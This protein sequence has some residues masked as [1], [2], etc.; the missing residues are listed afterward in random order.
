MKIILSALLVL[1][2]FKSFCFA[3]TKDE[4]K[5]DFEKSIATLRSVCEKI[6][7]KTSDE[8]ECKAY[9]G[10]KLPRD[11]RFSKIFTLLCSCEQTQNN[12]L[13]SLTIEDGIPLEDI[14]FTFYCS[15]IPFLKNLYD[16]K[17][18]APDSLYAADLEECIC[19]LNIYRKYFTF[20]Q[21]ILSE[22]LKIENTRKVGP[23][24]MYAV[25][26][27]ERVNLFHM[28]RIY[29]SV[30]DRV[31]ALESVLDLLDLPLDYKEMLK[32]HIESVIKSANFILTLNP[33][34]HR[35]LTN[36]DRMDL[37]TLDGIYKSAFLSTENAIGL[38]IAK[39]VAY[40]PLNLKVGE[41][42][43]TKEQQ[44]LYRPLL[45]KILTSAHLSPHFTSESQ[46]RHGTLRTRKSKKPKSKASLASSSS[47]LSSPASFLSSSP[48]SFS[49]DLSSPA[50]FPS[51]SPESFSS[52]L[53][54]PTTSSSS[55]P[56]SSPSAL[57]SCDLIEAHD[58][59]DNT[60]F[61]NQWLTNIIKASQT[62]GDT[63]GIFLKAKELQSMLAKNSSL[64]EQV[65]GA[66]AALAV[67][68]QNLE[69]GATKS[70]LSYKVPPEVEPGFLYFMDTPLCHMNGLRFRFI[71]ALFQKLGVKVD[72]MREGSRIHFSY[73]GQH[74]AIHLHDKHNG[75][76]DG[77]RISSLR[78][79]LINCG[80][81]YSETQSSTASSKKRK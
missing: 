79:F 54:S 69:Q 14:S 27:D 58:E 57:S 8:N 33:R 16:E 65:Q 17:N 70:S 18:I 48:E 35:A 51:S 55:S 9:F 29:R 47:A 62:K 43:L 15:V 40:Q 12:Q 11:N 44:S 67:K 61:I 68:L 74:T 24:N 31:K 42:F 20:V 76:L 50:S 4:F 1:C 23:L 81:I 64:L 46:P 75:E 63:F 59:M 45:D 49:G 5:H 6:Q 36:R 39:A 2:F 19:S 60:S 37:V 34:S 78:Q 52:D 3:G 32:K 10:N 30:L 66:T 53:S 7:A 71:D 26:V 21:D 22:H 38:K 72:K 80:F 41:L 25:Y 13:A 28:R 73:K 56:A 77:G